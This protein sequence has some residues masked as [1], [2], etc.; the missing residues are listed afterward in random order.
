V[1]AEYPN[2]LDYSGSC[3]LHGPQA[4]PWPPPATR[5]AR[6]AGGARQG[7]RALPGLLQGALCMGVQAPSAP[8]CAWSLFGRRPTG[9]AIGNALLAGV[10]LAAGLAP[11]IAP[12]KG[13]PRAQRR[14]LVTVTLGLLA[15]NTGKTKA[16]ST[17]RSSQAVPH[18]STNRALRCLTSEVE[19]DPVHST[20]YGRRRYMNSLSH[21]LAVWACLRFLASLSLLH[22]FTQGGARNGILD[23]LRGSSDKIGTIQR[24]LAWPLRKDDTHKSRS[25]RIFS[26]FLALVVGRRPIYLLFTPWSQSEWSNGRYP[27]GA[28]ALAGS[29]L[30]A[31]LRHPPTLMRAVL[32]LLRLAFLW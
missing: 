17:Q 3:C 24:R 29:R 4:M 1:R 11:G 25:V 5:A 16:D 7:S 19:R 20:R 12:R 6:S 13:G 28:Y 26:R 31:W 9:L 18:P 27:F 2:Q 30:C 8:S 15:Y 32:S 23:S 22:Y 21:T 10:G 14:E